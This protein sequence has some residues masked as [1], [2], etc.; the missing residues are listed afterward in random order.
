MKSEI[1]ICTG[2]HNKM[3]KAVVFDLDGTLTNTMPDLIITISEV[4]EVYGLPP[5]TEEE[6][7][8]AVNLSTPEFIKLCMSQLPTEEQKEE[9]VGV[10][11][12]HYK[13]HM[14]DKTHPYDGIV[15]LLHKLRDEGKKIAVL[16]NKDDI[17]VKFIC[18]TF[19]RGL[20]DELW[21]KRDEY[22]GK[23]DP[24]SA[25]AL[26]KVLGCEPR[27]IAYIGDSDVDMKTGRNA[28]FVTVG[29]SWGYR[30]AEILRETG[31]EYI[32]DS[33]ADFGKLVD[34]LDS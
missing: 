18:D 32:V 1:Q 3:I 26:M 25:F 31:A 21:G 17:N 23:P 29:A 30:P 13:N 16:S 6:V 24:T 7:L 14:V 27:E 19:F 8:S 11:L 5:I 4:R 2:E 10:Y 33:A 12:E 20:I 9:A 28:G 22:P 34:K 15:K